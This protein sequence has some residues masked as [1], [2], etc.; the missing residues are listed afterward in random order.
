MRSRILCVL[1]VATVLTC[2]LSGS[3]RADIILFDDHFPGTTVDTAKWTPAIDLHGTMTVGGSNVV[4]YAPNEGGV[5]NAASLISVPQ[6]TAS[7]GITATF[8]IG[9]AFQGSNSGFGISNNVGNG[10][11][12]IIL[13]SDISGTDWYF[14]VG[15]SEGTKYL[16][17][18]YV[19]PNGGLVTGD[20]VAFYWDTA[21]ASV[22]VRD[23]VGAFKY[24]DSTSVDIPAVSL[25]VSILSGNYNNNS[26]IASTMTFDRVTVSMIPEPSTLALLATGLIGLLCYAW[27]KRK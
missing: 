16:S 11:P 10:T 20:T 15:T 21:V 5:W 12:S 3:A 8:T 7:Q 6:F 14:Q 9:G 19:V 22:E 13:R 17:S 24:G 2:G 26:Y 25:G 27:R 18:A 1:A 23:S 4:L